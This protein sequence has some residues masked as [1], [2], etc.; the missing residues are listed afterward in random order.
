MAG[1]APMMISSPGCSP[2]RVLSRS[3]NPVGTPEI[4]PFSL[5]SSSISAK[6]LPSTSRAGLRVSPSVRFMDRS[7]I[8]FSA[9]SSTSE[10][11]A[12]WE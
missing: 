5:A 10:A 6:V 7:K 11:G 12:C 1:R 8:A 3:I 9:R 2:V 4:S